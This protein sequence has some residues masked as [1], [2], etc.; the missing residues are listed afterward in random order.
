MARY[1]RQSFRH[2][3]TSAKSTTGSR[4]ATPDQRR[5]SGLVGWR[6]HHRQRAISA[7]VGAATGIRW[8]P[9]LLETLLEELHVS[10]EA[11]QLLGV[12]LVAVRKR[13]YPRVIAIALIL[14]H[15]WRDDDLRDVL[16]RLALRR[17]RGSRMR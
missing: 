10:E 12:P 2:L 1:V 11:I 7:A 9:E 15:S 6:R 5:R 4:P 3:S 14:R 8:S 17:R 13:E 16:H